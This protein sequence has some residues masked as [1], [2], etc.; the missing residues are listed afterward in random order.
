MQW[1][2]L[3]RMNTLLVE[4]A[5]LNWYDVQMSKLTQTAKKV[6]D[7]RILLV[8][9]IIMQGITLYFSL[10]PVN[11]FAQLSAVQVINEVAEITQVPPGPNEPLS[12]GV[13]G[14]GKNLDDIE[15]IKAD[16][17]YNARVYKDSQNGDYV[18]G[19]SNKMIIY[20]RA[21]KR[22]VYEGPSPADL[23]NQEQTQLVEQL[24]T[25]VK[26]AGLIDTTYDTVPQVVMVVDPAKQKAINPQ[27]YAQV[28]AGDLVAIFSDLSLVVVYRPDSR[29]IINHGAFSFQVQ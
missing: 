26:A 2:P 12:F 8:V 15:A 29:Q 14:D 9:V 23:R 22:I 7:V 24:I 28:Q 6:F 21:Q 5:L 1:I 16:N 25:D 13:V 19:Y 17:S 3:F 20:R 4:I 27:F 10:N 18:L 11:L